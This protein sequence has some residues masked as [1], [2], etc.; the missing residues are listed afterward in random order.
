MNLKL[1]KLPKN[2]QK[3]I[4]K[5]KLVITDVDGVLT[6][7][8]MYYSKNGE[9][10]KKFHTRDGMGIELLAQV[11]IGTIFITKENSSIVKK[12]AQKVHVLACFIGIKNKE[13]MLE[14]ICKKFHV[15]KNEIAYIGDDVNDIDIIK[16]VGFS[17][18]P[19]DAMEEIRKSVDYVSDL[20]GGFG[21]LR[22]I[23]ELILN[24]I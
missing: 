20:D 21:V 12:R 23:S 5:I 16:Q 4:K 18:S 8:G 9:E 24:S 15:K 17:A 14:H 2:L 13:K 6:D 3:K 22:D 7:G 1:K 10:L 11:G 19:N